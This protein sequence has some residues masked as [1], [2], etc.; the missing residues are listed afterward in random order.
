VIRTNVSTAPLVGDGQ[1]ARRADAPG[2]HKSKDEREQIVRAAEDHPV[3]NAVPVGEFPDSKDTPIPCGYECRDKQWKGQRSTRQKEILTG[4]GA[5]AR[6]AQ[7]N[8][9]HRSE[10]ADDKDGIKRTQVDHRACG[11]FGET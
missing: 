8:E 10:I 2:E 3:R 11:P 6:C 1:R 5:P 4:I 9:D 7:S